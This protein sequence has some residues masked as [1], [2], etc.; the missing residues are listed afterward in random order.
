MVPSRI[1]RAPCLGLWL[2]WLPQCT[3]VAWCF[4]V[5][6]PRPT[7]CNPTDCSASGFPVLHYL[8]EFAQPHVH[9]DSDAIQPSNLP[10]P[11]LFLPR[12]FPRIRDFSNYLALHIR[13]LK[14]WSFSFSM[15]SSWIFRVNFLYG[16]LFDLLQSKGFSRLFS[17]TAV[18]KHQ[19]FSAQPSLRS[20]SHIP[21]WLLEKS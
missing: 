10:L 7:L 2:M 8:L 11:L 9:W 6:K 4:S 21:L 1:P 13:W 17:S 5:A 16:R 19:F 12:I 3:E 18:W 14:Y 20:D 15:S